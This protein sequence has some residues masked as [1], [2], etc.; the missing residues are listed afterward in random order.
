MSYKEQ[1]INL[2]DIVPDYKMGY[3]LAYV[4]GIAADEAQDDAFCERMLENYNNGSE[5]DKEDILLDD[6][7][8]SW[9]I[10]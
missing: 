10:G 7:L 8:E 9:G 6:C 3:I 5:D 1:I 2:L 4:Q